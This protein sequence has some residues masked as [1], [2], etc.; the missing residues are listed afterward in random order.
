[1]TVHPGQSAWLWRRYTLMVFDLAYL[2]SHL[3]CDHQTYH[4]VIAD[5]GPERILKGRRTVV[6]DQKVA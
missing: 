3:A 1:L 6:F 4:P 2:T 5:E